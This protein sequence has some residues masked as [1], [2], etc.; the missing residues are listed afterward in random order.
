MADLWRSKN[1]VL[2]LVGCAGDESKRARIE[3]VHEQNV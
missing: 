2:D 3:F 1:V